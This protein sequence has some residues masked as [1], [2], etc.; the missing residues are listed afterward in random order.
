MIERGDIRWFRFDRPD[1]RRPVLVLGRRATISA[2]SQIIV[3][4]FSTTIRGLAGEVVLDEIDGL[5]VRSTI[6]VEW[7][8]AVDRASVGSDRGPAHRPMARGEASRGPRAGAR[9]GVE[10]SPPRQVRPTARA[11]IREAIDEALRR[12][13]QKARR[14]TVPVDG[15]PKQLR[16]VKADAVR[17]E[18]RTAW[19]SDPRSN[20]R[21]VRSTWRL[22]PAEAPS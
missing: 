21:L 13:P 18:N 4:P 20:R 19:P 11:V 6:K 1:K 7:I 22:W 3:V 15:E 17:R 10:R 5:A 14:W 9:R 2:L 16:T 8:R 12:D